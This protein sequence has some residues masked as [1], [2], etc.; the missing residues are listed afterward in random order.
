MDKSPIVKNTYIST[1]ITTSFGR[2]AFHQN[3][4]GVKEAGGRCELKGIEPFICC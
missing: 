4:M 2:E 1:S 3:G